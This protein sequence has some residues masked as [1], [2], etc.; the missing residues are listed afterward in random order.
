MNNENA[1]TPKDIKRLDRFHDNIGIF[2]ET[3]KYYSSEID[4][5]VSLKMCMGIISKHISIAM[6]VN[7]TL[8]FVFTLLLYKAIEGEYINIKYMGFTMLC[9]VGIAVI[10][11]FIKSAFKK[12]LQIN[13]YR[14]NVD[15]LKCE[16]DENTQILALRIMNTTLK[17]IEHTCTKLYNYIILF[18][19]TSLGSFI[20]IM[21][22]HTNVK[23]VRII[24][25]CV[26]FLFTILCSG[27]VVI[28]S[29]TTSRSL[30]EYESIEK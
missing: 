7:L 5:K 20:T 16:N 9:V 13:L 15:K 27:L 26:W 21:T 24:A 12:L 25:G 14:N 18:I 2:I 6:Y 28:R 17:N 4:I 30:Y 22:Y 11:Y 8:L 1:L 19:C 29:V 3:A 10:L 23:H